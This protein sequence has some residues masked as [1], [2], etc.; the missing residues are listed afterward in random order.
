MTITEE[1]VK[2]MKVGSL[3]CKK[4]PNHFWLAEPSVNASKENLHG[5][6]LCH[7]LVE[8]TNDLCNYAEDDILVFTRGGVV[9]SDEKKILGPGDI[10]DGQTLSRIA[11]KFDVLKRTSILHLRKNEH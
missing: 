9:T 5:C 1:R 10:V 3:S 8:S 7:I 6:V 4:T 2:A 11:P